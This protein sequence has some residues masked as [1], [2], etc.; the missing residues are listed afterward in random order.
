MYQVLRSSRSTFETVRGL[1]YH[2]REW[3]TPQPDRA[4]LWLL[5]GWMDVSASWQFVVDALAHERYCIAPDWR[6]FGLTRAA[7]LADASP[8]PPPYGLTDHYLFADYLADVDFLIG[9]VNQRLGRA[10][11]A[12][13]DLVGHSMGGNVAMLYAGVRPARVRRLVNLEGFGLP[14]TRP[15]Q[16]PRRYAAW[17][18]ELHQL[19][20]GELT[21]K[22]YRG[23]DGV[24]QRLMKTNRRLPDDRARWLAQHWARPLDPQAP[25]GEWVILGDPAHKVRSSQLY[26]VD[27][28]LAVYGNIAA[29][30]LAVEASDDSLA[31]WFPR[32]EH[33]LAEYHRRLQ[34]VPRCRIARVEDAGHMLHHDQPQRVAALIEAHLDAPDGGDAPLGGRGA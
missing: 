1:R 13:I 31:Q 30:V 16:A 23:L 24:A 27:E 9:R 3:G 4:P 25:E 33:S 17:L 20:N 5:H 12:P 26:R 19:A 6:G 2:L 8:A 32:G 28:V 10:P 14:A 15:E 7:H 18:D 21:L 34:A 11:D 29:P 22:T